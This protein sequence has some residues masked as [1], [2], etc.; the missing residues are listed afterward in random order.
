MSKIRV[1]P[2]SCR[3]APVSLRAAPICQPEGGAH[4]LRGGFSKIRVVPIASQPVGGTYHLR[5][6]I[7]KKT[8]VPISCK[9]APVSRKAAL[10]I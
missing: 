10:I 4:H 9:A 6:G 5:S 8:V 7:S 3:A 1:V 2:V